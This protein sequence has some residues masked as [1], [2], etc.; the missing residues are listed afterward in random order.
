MRIKSLSLYRFRNVK[1]QKIEFEGDVTV[2]HGDNAQGKT[3]LLEA[4]YIVSNL[5]SFRTRKP[6]DLLTHG[7]KTAGLRAFV[8]SDGSLRK[9]SLT[10]EGDSKKALLDDKNP[11]SAAEYLSVL[12]TVFF[13]PEDMELSAGSNLLRR[14]Y[15]DRAVFT[16]DPGHLERLK[17]FSR[18]LRQRNEA[19][20]KKLDN[21]S[22]WSTQLAKLWWEISSARLSTLAEL[23][24][25]IEDTHRGVSG[26]SEELLVRLKGGEKFLKE[27]QDALLLKY[28]E[29][30]AEDRAKGYTRHGP[31]RDRV[32]LLLNG[33]EI[34]GH[35][36]QG[37]RRTAALSMKLALLG[38][39]GEHAGEKPVF[40][41]D[42][43][44]SELD[45]KRLGF[46]SDFI[47]G[48][49][50]QTLISTVGENDVPLAGKAAIQAF[51]VVMG[52]AS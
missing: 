31:H 51:Q 48:W 30:E 52:V 22:P 24:K 1:E 41:L 18:V 37:Q 21:L 26:V 23:S 7:E 5:H 34:S 36:S 11:A 38:W 12:R 35:G 20:R 50:G 2:F 28:L 14:R 29:D 25:S 15:L 42:D 19:L 9:L 27:G 17:D 39:T 44:G 13:G 49:K 40:L 16:R 32:E 8:E 33:R 4:V 3:N 6:H 47:A 45:P 43:P 46:L 10:I